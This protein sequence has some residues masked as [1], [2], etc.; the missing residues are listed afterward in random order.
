[1]SE[2]SVLLLLLLLAGVLVVL[3]VTIKKRDD[4]KMCNQSLDGATMQE[5]C[6][7]LGVQRK[8]T[9]GEV[10]KAFRAKARLLHPNN[11][12]TGNEDSFR[13]LAHAYTEL[14]KAK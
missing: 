4:G 9:V 8:A 2:S 12:T 1:M 14:V 6:D 7:L 10:K 11:K 13:R 5:Y 3:F